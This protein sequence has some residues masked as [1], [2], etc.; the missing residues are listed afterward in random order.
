METKALLFFTHGMNAHVNASYWGVYFERVAREGFALVAVDIMGHGYSEGKRALVE[1][2][3]VVFKD[4]EKMVEAFMGVGKQAPSPESFNVDLPQDVYSRLQQL[5]LF[6]HGNSMGGMIGMYMGLRLQENKRLKGLFRGAVL[7][8][9]ALSVS[10]PPPAVQALLRHLVVPLLKHQRMPP[11]VSSSS[12]PRASWSFDLSVAEQL[13]ICEMDTRDCAEKLPGVG[14]GWKG[15]MLWGTA[16]AYSNLYRGIDDDMSQVQYPFLLMHDPEDKVCYFAGSEKLLELSPSQ[17]KE[18]L[19]LAAG[20]L[21]AG[22]I[23]AQ[24][25]FVSTMSAWMRKR[26]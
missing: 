22:A 20:G 25:I 7:G 10:L 16:G 6:V 26:L 11:A 17:D 3:T 18:L 24:E 2:W 23:V 19:P 13:D 14:L 8:Y 5:P 4:L 1:D 9:P 12:K 15:A 21:H